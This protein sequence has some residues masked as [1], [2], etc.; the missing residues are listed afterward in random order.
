MTVIGQPVEY[1][2][3]HAFRVFLDGAYAG[4][5][6][7]AGPLFKAKVDVLKIQG[8]GALVVESITPGK[9]EFDPVVLTQ[10][11]S[12]NTLLR[13]WF[14]LTV[15]AGGAT[16]DL[17]I[18]CRKTVRIDQLGRDMN[19]IESYTYPDAIIS[20]YDEGKFDAKSSEFRMRSVTITHRIPQVT[21]AI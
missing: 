17:P 11:V 13:D 10:G 19:P 16:G 1:Y 12:S 7:T 6:V 8:G 21:P 4:E 18:D 3:E 20:E 14:M 9:A 5:F 2:P 15:N